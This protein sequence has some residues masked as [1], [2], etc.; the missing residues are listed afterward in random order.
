MGAKT[1]LLAYSTGG[2]ADV[3]RNRPDASSPEAAE[4]AEKFVRRVHPGWSVTPRA[5]H[6]ADLSEM[7]YPP[8]NIAYA[9]SLPGLDILCSQA[10]MLDR[11]SE[12]PPRYLQAARGRTVVLHAMHSVVDFLAVAIWKDGVLIRSLSLSPDCGIIEDIG[13]RLPFETR[14]WAGDHPV[15]PLDFVP[16]PGEPGPSEEDPYPLPFHPLELGEVALRALFGFVVEGRLDPDDIDVS[17][18]QVHGFDLVDPEGP[19]PEQREAERDA[20]LAAMPPPRMFR[21]QDGVLVEVDRL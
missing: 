7:V 2:V 6:G 20:L 10:V 21:M 16:L 8:E 4:K 12:L 14:Y 19:T 5:D 3:L 13:E 1:S 11:P 18:V 9:A 15:E 17:A